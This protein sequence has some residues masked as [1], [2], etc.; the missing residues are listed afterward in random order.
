M[1]HHGNL[2]TVILQERKASLFNLSGNETKGPV[3]LKMC[4]EDDEEM[5]VLDVGENHCNQ[6][7]EN[8]IC[9]QG[10]SERVKPGFL[11]VK[12]RARCH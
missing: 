5:S 8:L 11:D 3:K 7:T 1:S 4:R 6:E 9:I 2:T 12:S 10:T